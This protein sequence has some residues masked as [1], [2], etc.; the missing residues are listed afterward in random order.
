MKNKI[1]ASSS[2][3]APLISAGVQST[4]EIKE[5]IDNILYDSLR[6]L[7]DMDIGRLLMVGEATAQKSGA[8]TKAKSKRVV[9]KVR[10]T[11]SRK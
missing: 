7:A 2:K 10:R 1:L 6:D 5:V 4:A 11:K 8:K 9:R 3:A